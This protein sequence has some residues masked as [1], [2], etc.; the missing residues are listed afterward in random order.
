MKRIALFLATNPAIMLVLSL[1]MR[2][3]GVEPYL[4]EQGLKLNALLV[5]AGAFGFCA[6][7]AIMVVDR[8]SA[9]DEM[10]IALAARSLTE[11]LHKQVNGARC[12]CT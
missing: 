8:A 5:F 3:L 11:D 9:G 10:V 1:S 6:P 4:D 2:L 12:R 7:I